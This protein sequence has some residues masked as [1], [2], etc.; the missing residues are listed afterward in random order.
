MNT[1][2]TRRGKPGFVSYVLV[3]ATGAILTLLMVFTYRRAMDGQAVQNTTSS[4]A[5]TTARRRTRSCARSWRSRRTGRSGRCSTIPTRAR[6]SREP[7][8]LA[9]IFTEALVLA[10]ART[11]IPSNL[12]TSL[13]IPNLKLGN[14]RRFGARHA[15]R[16]VQGDQA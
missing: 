2:P 9:E 3:L 13:N 12:L 8:A 4:C 6:R 1:P 15:K 16:D 11:S 5:W 7:A 10:N 14:C